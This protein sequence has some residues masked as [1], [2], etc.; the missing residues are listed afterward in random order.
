MV[1]LEIQCCERYGEKEAH[2][3][4]NPE[5]NLFLVLLLRHAGMFAPGFL[6]LWTVSREC[7]HENDG[8]TN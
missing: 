7:N 2:Q 3:H 4:G 1:G 8:F 6:K 5:E